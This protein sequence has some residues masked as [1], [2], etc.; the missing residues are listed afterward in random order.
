MKSLLWT[1][2]AIALLAASG[3]A[4]AGPENIRLGARTDSGQAADA[5]RQSGIPSPYAALAT[6][7]DSQSARDH[8]GMT[9]GGGNSPAPAQPAADTEALGGAIADYALDCLGMPYQFGG[10]SPSGFDSSG[11]L[12]YVYRFSAAG[13][14]LPRTIEEQ[15]MQGEP[16]GGQSLLLPG[17]A[18]FFKNEK[19]ISF[20]GIYIGNH[21]FAAA[22]TDG[23][24][25]SSLSSPYWQ[26]R[27]AGARRM[28]SKTT[29]A[30][31]SGSGSADSNGYAGPEETGAAL[32][33]I[34]YFRP[35]AGFL[36]AAK[37]VLSASAYKRMEDKAQ[38]SLR[39]YEQGQYVSML[40]TNGELL[41]QIDSLSAA[42]RSRIGI[43]STELYGP[44]FSV[45]LYDIS[46]SGSLKPRKED[47]YTITL[48]QQA[49]AEQLWLQVRSAFPAPYLS[50]VKQLR[51]EVQRGGIARTE[52]IGKGQVRL[53]LD[54][55]D[56]TPEARDRTRWTLAH[57]L[58]KLVTQQ[59]PDGAELDHLGTPSAG[60]N[61]AGGLLG[62]S[63]A[64]PASG[65]S[66]WG[67]Y[68]KDSLLS[69]YALKFWTP[70]VAAAARS[71]K[72]MSLI[73]SKLFFREASAYQA[74]EDIADAWTAF[75]LYD[76][77]DKPAD[78]REEKMLFFYSKPELVKAR[79]QTRAG[80]GL[81]KSYPKG[82]TFAEL[83]GPRTW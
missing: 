1:G 10:A 55:S 52:T 2:T 24:R 82:I 12:Y 44:R 61:G 38:L 60:A 36:S 58:G 33:D 3:T 81:S 7:A 21:Q 71:G 49:A 65:S 67:Y 43:K 59:G 53:V 15:F 56:L 40:K 41:S 6:V 79:T 48:M 28:T 27:Y 83:I 74:S 77:P 32:E 5:L 45:G 19:S 22:T 72:S 9:A 54:P 29:E 66:Q 75:V 62:G 17:D 4:Y 76:K 13:K 25:L 68:R 23:V 35:V 69:G 26:D 39:Q 11:F 70:E 16:V 8:A 34:A 14:T 78:R 18:V 51:L 80:L 50:L 63:F 57:E 20:A 37:P 64:G 73:Y 46:A 31:K 30:P 42:D 47:G